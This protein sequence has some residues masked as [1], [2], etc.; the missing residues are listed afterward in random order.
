[1]FESQSLPNARSTFLV[2]VSTRCGRAVRIANQQ[3]HII[4]VSDQWNHKHIYNGFSYFVEK[5][6]GFSYLFI[7]SRRICVFEYP[8]TP[9]TF[10]VMTLVAQI[11]YLKQVR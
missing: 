5:I 11:G 8:L 6:S 1:M 3:I 9:P 10:L 2:G 4:S 7:K